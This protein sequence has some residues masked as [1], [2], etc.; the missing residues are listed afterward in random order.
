MRADRFLMLDEI[1]AVV[2][3]L[4]EKRC[5]SDGWR[6]ILFRL[7][8]CCGLRRKEISH[9]K[10]SDVILDGARPGIAVRKET[11]KGRNGKR[12]SRFVPL[13]WD[14]GTKEDLAAWVARMPPGAFVL[15]SGSTGN[16]PRQTHPGSLSKRWRT[17]IRILGPSRQRQ[18]SI[19][20]GRHSFITHAINSGHSLAEVRDAAGHYDVSVTE[21][22][23]HSIPRDLPDIWSTDETLPY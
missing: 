2:R 6:L 22:Y 19:H 18:V 4:R 9:L 23:L 12:K 17:A 15:H 10:V 16:L 11:T 13:W 8:C 1:L 20:G 14:S 21:V 3:H 7:S 5:E